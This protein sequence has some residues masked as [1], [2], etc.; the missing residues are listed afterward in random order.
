MVVPAAFAGVGGSAWR[1]I[2]P[3]SAVVLYAA[4]EKEVCTVVPWEAKPHNVAEAG[5]RCSTMWLASTLLSVHAAAAPETKKKS[6]GSI[7]K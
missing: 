1:Q 4:P 2:P 3:L 6:T 5:A 7:Q